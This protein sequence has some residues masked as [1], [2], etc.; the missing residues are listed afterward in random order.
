[1][2]VTEVRARHEAAPTFCILLSLYN[3]ERYLRMQLESI[4]AQT[5]VRV[6][7]HARDDGSTDGT[8][9]LFRQACDE[10]GVGYSLELGEN[11]GAAG[12]FMRLLYSAPVGFDYYAPCDQDDVWVADKLKRAT[13][14]LERWAEKPALYCAGHVITDE[15]LRPIG[16]SVP[17]RKVGFGNALVQNI[18]QGST[19]VFNPIALTLIHSVGPPRLCPLHDIWIYLVVSAFGTVMYDDFESMLYRQHDRNDVGV[20]LGLARWRKRV[21]RH[22]QKRGIRPTQLAA[23]LEQLAGNRLSAEDRALLQ[24]FTR[25][26]G[27]LLR[28]TKLVLDRR[29]WRQSRSD[30]LI[31]RVLI[32]LGRY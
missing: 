10:L 19:A 15:H 9:A 24:Q 7:I 12:S 5:G 28:R 22:L 30:D 14:M 13:G 11:L 8:V 21:V 27:S 3:G 6:Y 2:L 17:P 32:L 16:R 25:S 4:A 26:H 29:I 31:W 20:A 23:E 18:V 1:M